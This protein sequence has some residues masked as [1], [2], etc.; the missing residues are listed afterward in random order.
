MVLG[1]GYL[2]LGL[3]WK[4]RRIMDHLA[5]SDLA[6]TVSSL[7][8]P[9]GK[10]MG[11]CWLSYLSPP[12]LS[13]SQALFE[14]LTV[15]AVGRGVNTGSL[16]PPLSTSVEFPASIHAEFCLAGREAVCDAFGAPWSCVLFSSSRI[17]PTPILG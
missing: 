5:S 1:G 12:K 8:R 4:N 10:T 17:P 13:G 11:G 3:D 15:L 2:V 7:P 16:C 9:S 6:F 14:T